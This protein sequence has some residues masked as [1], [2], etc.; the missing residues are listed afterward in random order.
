MI[1][2][3]IVRRFPTTKFWH[4]KN[5]VFD[6]F[7][8]G[9]RKEIFKIEHNRGHRSA[10]ENVRVLLPEDGKTSQRDCAKLKN[11]RRAKYDRHSRTQELDD[12]Q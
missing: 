8:I 9:E 4:C 12:D 6:I 1:Q 10:Q 2:D 11:I 3:E 5:S 7:R